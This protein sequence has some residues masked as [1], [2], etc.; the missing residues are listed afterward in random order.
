MYNSN[1]WINICIDIS[2]SPFKRFDLYLKEDKSLAITLPKFP[3]AFKFCSSLLYCHKDPEEFEE[4]SE[5]TIKFHK[6]ICELSAVSTC[7]SFIYMQNRSS[8]WTAIFKGNQSILIP[9]CNC[10]IPCN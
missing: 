6:F 9:I 1:I 8:K 7:S 3:A 4:L 10:N 2:C 5:Y